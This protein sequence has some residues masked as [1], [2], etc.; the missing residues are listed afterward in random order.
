[1]QIG[2]SWETGRSTLD[3]D[4]VATDFTGF[5]TD[6]GLGLQ[7][8]FGNILSR[9]NLSMTLTALEQSGESQTLSAPRLTVVNNLPAT[10]SDGKV[11]Y[12]YEE[13]TVKQQLVPQTGTL[14]TLVPTG[15]P[16]KLTSGVTLDVVA[17]IGGDGQTIMLALKASRGPQNRHRSS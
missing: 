10:I 4:R 6:V 11:Q 2:A 1:M 15:K 13:Y 17:S 9:E 3:P 8:T 14:S 7:E 5:G 12:Y 16:T